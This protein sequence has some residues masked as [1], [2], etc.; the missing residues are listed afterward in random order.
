M[1]GEIDKSTILFQDFNTTLSEV[2]RSNRQKISR[3]T[4][5]L[6]SI[7]NQLDLLDTYKI[8]HPT[9]TECIFSS[10]IKYLSRQKKFR[11]FKHTLTNSEE[12]KSYKVCS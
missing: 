8:L 9:S 2:D 11:A 12:Q 5:D 7:I 1:R 6:N 10:D 3:D 4:G